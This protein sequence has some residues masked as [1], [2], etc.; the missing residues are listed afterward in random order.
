MKRIT[1]VML[2]I[3]LTAASSLSFGAVPTA[4]ESV[5][6]RR[7]SAGSFAQDESFWLG[8]FGFGEDG[9][10]T[11]GGS[12]IYVFHKIEIYREGNGLMAAIES[13]G[14]QT[15]RQLVCDVKLHGR[16]AEFYFKHYGET[17]LFQNYKEGQLLL[18][19]ERTTRNKR[20]LLL[21]YWGAFQPATRPLRSGRVY[22]KKDA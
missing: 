18:T 13:N 11:A 7:A 21:T 6:K 14:Y 2:V 17:N 16:R 5:V 22:F 3:A 19:L 10:K 8:T 9:G 20:A 15:A 1:L 12:A 4:S